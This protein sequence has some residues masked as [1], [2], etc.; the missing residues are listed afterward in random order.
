V[1]AE[2][3]NAIEINL[4]PPKPT[5]ASVAKVALQHGVNANQVFQW[6]RLYRDGKRGTAPANTIKLLPVS[7]AEDESLAKSEPVEAVPASSGAIHIE[8]RARSGSVSKAES[9]VASCVLFL[10]ACA[11]DRFCCGH[12]DLDRCWCHGGTLGL[13]QLSGEKAAFPTNIP[14]RATGIS[15]TSTVP[16]SIRLHVT[17]QP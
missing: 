4:F 12:E 1:T 8:L 5:Q 10:R 7:L 15:G 14:V 9:I 13:L 17:I 3:G 6:R 11:D 16:Q 2:D